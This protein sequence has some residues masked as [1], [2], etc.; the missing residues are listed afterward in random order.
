MAMDQ[1]NIPDFQYKPDKSNYNST[2]YLGVIFRSGEILNGANVLDFNSSIVT[3]S[4]ISNSV[5][6]PPPRRSQW[7]TASSVIIIS[8]TAF[9]VRGRLQLARIL[10]FPYLSVWLV[11]TTI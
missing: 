7:N 6:P 2:F 9:P 4:V 8:M 3:P 5:N 10:D 11:R 1:Y